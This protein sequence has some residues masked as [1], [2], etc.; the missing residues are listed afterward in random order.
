MSKVSLGLVG[1]GVQGR[2]NLSKSAQKVCEAELVAC[3]DVDE[4]AARRMVHDGI[5]RR[6]YADYHEMLAQEDLDAVMIAVPHNQLHD[7]AI[8]AIEAGC[9][10]LLEKPMATSCAKANEIVEAAHRAGVQVMVGYTERFSPSR[11][12]MKSLLDRGAIGKIVAVSAGKGSGPLP[13]WVSDPA[14][15]GGQLLYLGVHLVDQVLWMLGRRARSVYGHISS[16]T[17]QGADDTS[18]YM[19]EFDDG[20]FAQLLCSMQVAGG[21]DFVEVIGTEGF[22]RSDWPGE[23]LTVQSG[24][25]SE[26]QH[27]TTIQPR[28]G[29]YFHELYE[30]E[31]RDFVLAVGEHRPV[32]IP[33]EAGVEVLRIIDAVRASAASDGKVVL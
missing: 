26:Y 12:L 6:W 15:G 1:C 28:S 8:A 22:V 25:V 31:V 14:Q 33:G 16:Y 20:V 9:T 30:R 24:V 29:N 2:E 32:T 7:V 4:A 11:L 18:T 5:Y 13:G 27:V 19:V 10:I 23:R 17:P 21:F 3:A